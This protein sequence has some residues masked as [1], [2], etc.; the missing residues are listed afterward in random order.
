MEFSVNK[1]PV[2]VIKEGAFG[3]NFFRHIYSG[4]TGN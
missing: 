3:G 1:T 4:F 2:Q